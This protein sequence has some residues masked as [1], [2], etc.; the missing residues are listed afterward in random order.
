[1]KFL[2]L[3]ILLLFNLSCSTNNSEADALLGFW[4]SE[5]Y[6]VVVE[7]TG[8]L[9]SVSAFAL[10]NGEAYEHLNLNQY[11]FCNFD[12]SCFKT[13]KADEPVICKNGQNGLHYKGHNLWRTDKKRIYGQ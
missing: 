8:E 12:E 7:K 2:I 6:Y 9:Y 3:G 1:M 11:Y 5:N 10:Y 4:Q 13:E